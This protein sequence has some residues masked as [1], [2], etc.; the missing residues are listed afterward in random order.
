MMSARAMTPTD[1]GAEALADLL[2]RL[3]ARLN[4]GEPVDPAELRREYPEHAEELLRLLPAVRLMA[5]LSKSAEVDLIARDS[6]GQPLGELGDFR[7]IREVGRGGM[8]VVYEA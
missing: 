8:G 1:T 7:L 5:D 6:T 3:T 4:A 2:E